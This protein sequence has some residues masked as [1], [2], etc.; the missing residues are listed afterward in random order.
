[1]NRL[2]LEGSS[3]DYSDQVTLYGKI[4]KKSFLKKGLDVK[5]YKKSYIKKSSNFYFLFKN[6]YIKQIFSFRYFPSSLLSKI[7]FL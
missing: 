1:V 7:S 3:L 5:K 6:R 2:L 4:M